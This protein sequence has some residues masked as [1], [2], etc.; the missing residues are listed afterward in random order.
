MKAMVYRRYGT[1]D[2]LRCEEIDRPTIGDDSVCIRIRAAGVNPLDWHFIRGTPYLEYREAVGRSLQ[3]LLRDFP[4]ISQS[5][6]VLLI[7]QGSY[8]FGSFAEAS[9]SRQPLA[10]IQW[11]ELAEA[12]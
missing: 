8:V 5:V 11:P 9:A 2:V 6:I 1:A 4:K 7:E 12:V 3:I 10:D